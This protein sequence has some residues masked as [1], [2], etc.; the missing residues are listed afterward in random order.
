M[1]NALSGNGT[2]I[3]QEVETFGTELFNVV[4]CDLLYLDDQLRELLCRD[5]QQIRVMLFRQDQGMT[6][7]RLGNVEN[8]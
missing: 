4:G 3:D 8:G 7:G 2:C 6:L 5:L 1:G